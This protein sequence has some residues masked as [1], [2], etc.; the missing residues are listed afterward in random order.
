MLTPLA[1][2]NLVPRL[3]SYPVFNILLGPCQALANFHLIWA[4]TTLASTIIVIQPFRKSSRCQ[5]VW[6]HH[7][8]LL[9]ISRTF[10]QSFY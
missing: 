2:I 7:R 5:K 3:L 6:N 10:P 4:I 9:F 8:L 1:D